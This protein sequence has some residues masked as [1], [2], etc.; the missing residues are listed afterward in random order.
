VQTLEQHILHQCT[1]VPADLREELQSECTKDLPLATAPTV[2]RRGTKG[3]KQQQTC[4]APS[5][6]LA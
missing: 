4:C 2:S 1:K 3:G 6:T 5:R